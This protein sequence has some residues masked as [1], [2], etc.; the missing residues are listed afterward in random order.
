MVVGLAGERAEAGGA[1]WAVGMV[2]DLV[3]DWEAGLAEARVGA[4]VAGWVE[5]EAAGTVAAAAAGW[6]AA[7][8]VVVTPSST[9]EAVVEASRHLR[10]RRTRHCMCMAHSCCTSGCRCSALSSCCP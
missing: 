9:Q 10:C 5:A 3:A 1:G 7:T 6:A 8:V 4:A 2:A